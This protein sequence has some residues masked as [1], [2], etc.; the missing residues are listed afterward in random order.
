MKLRITGGHTGDD[1]KFIKDFRK[2]LKYTGFADDVEI[3]TDFHGYSR[4]DFLNSLTVFSVPALRGY[5]FGLYLLEALAAGVPVVQPKV[6]AF[7]EIIN[8]TNG[9]IVYEPNDADTLAGALSE[10]LL[11]PERARKFGQNGR[12]SV[13]KYYSIVNSAKNIISTYE[14]SIQ[15]QL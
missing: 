11:N 14:K 9:G 15:R 10:F 3:I 1:N 7:P 8:K 2:K 4:T 13:L 6:G 12:K 5:A